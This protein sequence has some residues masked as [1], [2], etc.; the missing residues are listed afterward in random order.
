[1]VQCVRHSSTVSPADNVESGFPIAI[2]LECTHVEAVS[3]QNS[4]SPKKP[5][6]H[7]HTVDTPSTLQ[8][9]F[10]SH[11]PLSDVA[12][13]FKSQVSPSP[14]PPSTYPSLQTQV[15][16]PSSVSQVALGSHPPLSVSQGS[17]MQ[18]AVWGW[19]GSPSALLIHCLSTQVILGTSLS[20]DLGMNG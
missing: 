15:V 8:V 5:V 16:I 3:L 13:G 17:A 19:T 6:L 18:K 9:A 12:Q 1:M 4:P 7:A 14:T 2:R 20:A 11:P 10:S